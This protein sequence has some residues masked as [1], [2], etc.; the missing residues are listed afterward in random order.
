[1]KRVDL[2]EVKDKFSRYLAEAEH[3]QIVIT[4]HGKPAGVLIGFGSEDG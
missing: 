1:M 4:K 3:K 2:A